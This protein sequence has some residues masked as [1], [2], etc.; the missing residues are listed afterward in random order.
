MMGDRIRFHKM[1]LL[2]MELITWSIQSIWGILHLAKL[3]VWD[4]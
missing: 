2:Y 3:L 4:S 1:L